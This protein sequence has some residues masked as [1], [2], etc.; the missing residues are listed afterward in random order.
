MTTP[1]D[2]GLSYKI[3]N[4]QN[5]CPEELALIHW[6]DRTISIVS[7]CKECFGFGKQILLVITVLSLPNTVGIT[8]NMYLK[9]AKMGITND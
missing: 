4:P 7:R 3:A 2:V 8:E 9:N 6:D 1:D 5:N